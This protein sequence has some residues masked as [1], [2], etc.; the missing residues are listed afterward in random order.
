M[1]EGQQGALG[2]VSKQ[3]AGGA[4]PAANHAAI[5]ASDSRPAETPARDKREKSELA[6]PYKV[7]DTWSVRARREG[8]DIFLSGFESSTGASKELRHRVAYMEKHGKPHGGGPDQT[9]VAK[10]MQEH[11]LKH[12][13]SLKGADQEA[14]RINRYLRA[15]RLQTIELIPMTEVTEGLELPKGACVG[16]YFAVFLRPFTASRAIPQGL[17]DH[18][19]LLMTKTGGSD[20]LR[21]VLANLKVSEVNHDHIQGLVRALEAEEFARATV[22]Q[23]QA[24]LRRLFNHARTKWHWPR[25]DTNPA[26]GLKLAGALAKRVRVM[27]HDEQARMDEALDYCVNDRI[28][29]AVMLLTE[30]AMR[31]EECIDT[32]KWGGVDWDRRILRLEDAKAG[33]RDVPLSPKAIEILKGMGPS[34]DP[35]EKIFGLSYESLKAAWRRTCERAGIKDLNIH[36]LRR[37]AATRMGLKSG[38]LFIVQALTGHKTLEM[39]KRYMNVKAEDVVAVM[40]SPEVAPQASLPAQTQPSQTAG[41]MTQETLQAAM[42]MLQAAAAQLN[43]KAAA[44]APA[45]AHVP[46]Q[47]AANDDGDVSAVA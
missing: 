23:E 47:P 44:S 13:P 18:R 29:P 6:V 7:G 24:L 43:V 5:H 33:P 11:A 8:C 16:K 17:E 9:T 26:C 20:R 21:A 28:Q 37:T 46:A 39:V 36:D 45:S 41:A 14:R 2:A 32:A 40:H 25:P 3:G 10:A 31:A 1:N 42:Q 27:S 22:A 19:R 30:T 15:A 4:V 38:N 34:A 12:L 35:D